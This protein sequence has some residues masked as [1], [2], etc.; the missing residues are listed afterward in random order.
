MNKYITC[1]SKEQMTSILNY[2]F[3][4]GYYYGRSYWDNNISTLDALLKEVTQ[5]YFNYPHIVINDDSFKIYNDDFSAEDKIKITLEEFFLL[6][7][8]KEVCRFRLNEKYEAIINDTGEIK[9]GCETFDFKKVK[10]MVEVASKHFN[11]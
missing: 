7:A 11:W 6:T 8:R 2:L 10:E 5:N 4:I 3:S 1:S 9:V